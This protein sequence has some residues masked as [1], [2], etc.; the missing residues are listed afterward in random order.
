MCCVFYDALVFGNLKSIFRALTQHTAIFVSLYNVNYTLGVGVEILSVSAIEILWWLTNFLFSGFYWGG[1]GACGTQPFE[2]GISWSTRCWWFVNRAKRL[3]IAVELVAN[4]SMIFIDEP[5]AS[6]DARSAS[7]V[8]WTVRNIVNTGRTLVCTIHQPNI[9]IFELF[10]EVS[11]SN[12]IT[13]FVYLEL[14]IL[15]SSP[16]LLP[17]DMLN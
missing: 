14:V 9:D 10:D 5:T 1:D 13:V 16:Y 2:M 3:T 4:P 17:F 6:L 8:M 7:I 12:L 15:L 11:I